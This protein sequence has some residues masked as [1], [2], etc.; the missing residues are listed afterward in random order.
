[1]SL[2]FEYVFGGLELYLPTTFI[3]GEFNTKTSQGKLLN[4]FHKSFSKIVGF[5]S[6]GQLEMITNDCQ[7]TVHRG[8]YAR[9]KALVSDLDLL[10]AFTTDDQIR[11]DTK[12]TWDQFMGEK[13]III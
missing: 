12:N 1:M 7:I 13:Y 2:F 3:D 5:D 8:F 6:L 9:N 11:G 4:Q 10:I